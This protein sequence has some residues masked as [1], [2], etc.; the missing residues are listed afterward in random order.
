MSL[1]P[2][3][4]D[5]LKG[6]VRKAAPGE[7]HTLALDKDGMLYAT[8]W[9]QHGQLGTG[10]SVTTSFEFCPVSQLAP[11]SVMAIAAGSLFSAALDVQGRVFA[12]GNDELGQL[13]T[14]LSSTSAKETLV[15]SQVT[16]LGGER[17]IDLSCGEA[18]VL[19]L[20][21]S[22]KVFGW[23]QGSDGRPTP[24][25]DSKQDTFRKCP[26]PVA[27]VAIAQYYVIHASKELSYIVR[28]LRHG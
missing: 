21:E 25:Q 22:G 2:K 26:E 11:H 7:A 6:R 5:L 16:Q 23:G 27:K 10:P 28:Q 24:Q 14:Q 1:A 12:W 9:G 8:G 15:P 19:V 3:R 18:S 13:G 17:A 20:C 4:V